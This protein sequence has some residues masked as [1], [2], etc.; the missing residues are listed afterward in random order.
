MDAS[1]RRSFF[2]PRWS[3]VPPR[4][5]WPRAS[6]SRVSLGPKGVPGDRD[7]Y[8]PAI[9][10]DGRYVAFAS[11]ATNLVAND[12]NNEADV[13]VR[14]RLR[15]GT[16]ERVSV[17]PGGAQSDGASGVF[18]ARNGFAYGKV[19][20]SPDARF[21]AF[22]STATT[23]VPGDTNG[24][25]DV[26]V[27]DRQAG[28]TTRASVGQGGAEANDASF[29]P[30]ISDDGRYVAF[31]S[32]ATTLVS[33]DTNGVA[34]VFVR[35]MQTGTTTR[36]SVGQGSAEANDASLLPYLS[37]DGRYLVFETHATNLVPIASA[38]PGTT[39]IELVRGI[40][41]GALSGVSA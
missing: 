21:V 26:F 1:R 22:A 38:N 24:V 9:S 10:T 11:L 7:S 3:V 37:G 17:G 32:S 8:F 19:A 2:A 25:T 16:T 39:L 29:D 33:G 4:R 23:L 27:R 31:W 6:T 14:D 40:W 36:A 15:P 41:T 20:M 13:F 35:D 5:P 34:D 30:A 18:L 12:L 28:T